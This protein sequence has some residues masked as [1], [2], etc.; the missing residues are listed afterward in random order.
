[1]NFKKIDIL[2]LLTIFL[3]FASVLVY[4][5]FFTHHKGGG[6]KPLPPAGKPCQT[7]KDCFDGQN[8]ISTGNPWAGEKIC[9]NI[10]LPGQS[11]QKDADCMNNFCSDDN[12]CNRIADNDIDCKDGTV[13]LKYPY[14][15]ILTGDYNDLFID[16]KDVYARF[17]TKENANVMD[18]NN[19]YYRVVRPVCDQDNGCSKN[20]TKENCSFTYTNC[21]KDINKRKEGDFCI[22]DKNCPN[23]MIC[24]EN[25]CS[26][27]K[28]KGTE[29]YGC[30]RGQ[31]QCNAGLKCLDNKCSK[32]SQCSVSSDCPQNYYC[33]NNAVCKP[34]EKAGQLCYQDEA[35]FSGK[36]DERVNKC[37]PVN[38]QCKTDDDCILTD[39]WYCSVYEKNPMCKPKKENNQACDMGLDTSCLSNHC[40]A[41]EPMYV[42]KPDVSVPNYSAFTA[43]NNYVLAEPVDFNKNTENVVFVNCGS[44]SNPYRFVLKNLSG[45]KDIKIG[46]DVALQLQK[47]PANKFGCNEDEPFPSTNVKNYL[48]TPFV[49]DGKDN[50][51]Y[52]NYSFRVNEEDPTAKPFVFKVT[53]ID[54]DKKQVSLKLPYHL[55]NGQDSV[56][57]IIDGYTANGCGNILLAGTKTF[58]ETNTKNYT[59][60]F[61]SLVLTK[62]PT[63]V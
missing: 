39:D 12:A 8:C 45:E 56:V 14:Y 48:S 2:I 43:I 36:C 16:C 52:F 32:V 15:T 30:I 37:A 55:R 44:M 11:C 38:K 21:S 3:L 13:I 24:I 19:N 10:L 4:K 60:R 50:G 47:C 58:F 5:L 7:K 9:Q 35:C 53:D 17:T 46:D 42:C 29:G 27:Q 54:N 28:E 63:I 51:D 6:K 40:A 33:T 26:T 22:V 20:A 1:M 61:E 59:N 25:K 49:E 18:L 23:G 57:Y 41:L 34:M 31:N 62:I